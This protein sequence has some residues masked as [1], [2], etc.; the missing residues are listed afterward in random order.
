MESY[1]SHNERSLVALLQSGD[2]AAFT[3]IYARYWKRLFGLA[4]HRLQSRVLAEDVVQEVFMGLWNRREQ[5]VIQSLFAYLAAATRYAI[6]RQL[7]LR[8]GLALEEVPLDRT[9]AEDDGVQLKF[10]EE[11][12]HE[13]VN[14]LPERCRLVFIYSRHLG[15]TNKEIAAELH[16][17]EKAVEKHIT[18]ALS[19]LRLR[20]R[21]LFSAFPI[22]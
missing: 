18:R 2:E 21:H 22:L 9:V 12:M 19:I 8:A 11:M 17:S 7:S 4:Y 20:I 10:L 5:A 16:I 14:R 13:E 6:I 15:M 3:E 1:R